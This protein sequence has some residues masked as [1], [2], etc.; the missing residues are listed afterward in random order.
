M[1]L[2]RKIKYAF[3]HDGDLNGLKVQ[4][5]DFMLLSCGGNN[6]KKAPFAHDV[7]LKQPITECRLLIKFTI[8]CTCTLL[9]DES[10][11]NRCKG[12]RQPTEPTW[13]VS[14]AAPM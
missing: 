14:D 8:R 13:L 9:M 1:S 3:R 10:V 11:L 6:D 5:Q 2:E 12:T 4:L 7:P